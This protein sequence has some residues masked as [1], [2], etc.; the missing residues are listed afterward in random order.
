MAEESQ[1]LV[2]FPHP[3]D[4]SFSSAGTLARYIDNGVPVTYACLTLGQMGRNLGNPPFATRETLPDIREKELEK[5][6]EAIGITDLR[7]MGLRDK[8]VEFEP[9][10]EMDAMVKSL[11]DE[12]Q[13]SVIISFYPQFA[14]H[15]DHEA[16]AEA[17]VRTVGR[18]PESERPR[19]QLVA[20]SND[21]HEK[22]GAPDILNEISDYK[23]VKLRT[24]EAHAS[25]TGPFLESLAT[26]DVPGEAHSFLEV[27]PYWTY[28]FES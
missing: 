26:P 6:M 28:N 12:L 23:E 7:K 27:E 19:L 5:A 25:Q 9:H 21:A 13:P 17:V 16:T 15:P 8:T 22:L 11:I 1:V 3:D 2:I 14:V 20:F 4:E 10:D 18:M 24:F